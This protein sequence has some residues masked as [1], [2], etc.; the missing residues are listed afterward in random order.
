M[1]GTTFATTTIPF[2]INMSESVNVTGTPRIA[3]DVGGVTR[4]ATYASGTGTS[5]LTFNYDMVAGDVDLD[6]VTLTSPIDLNGGTLK[7]LNGNNATLTFTVPNTSNIKVNYPSLGMDF[8]ADADGRFTLNGTAYNDLSSFVT[9][10]GGNFTRASAATSQQSDGTWVSFASGQPRITNKGLLIEGSIRNKNANY[11]ANPTNTTGLTLGG[12]PSATLSVANDTAALATAGLQNIVTSG[13]VYKLDNSAGTAVASAQIS[14]GTGNTNT[15]VGSVYIRVDSG[16]YNLR[17]SSS[18]SSFGSGSNTAYIRKLWGGS[19]T[20]NPPNG[21][22]LMNIRA[23]AGSVV[24][25]ILN[26]LEE[27]S[28]A[29]SLIVVAGAAATREADNFTIPAGTWYSSTAGTFRTSTYHSLSGTV[30]FD[31]NSSS[32]S[33]SSLWNDSSNWIFEVQSSGSSQASI[34]KT[35]TASDIETNAMSYAN[36]NFRFSKEGGAISSDTSGTVP[37]MTQLYIGRN[38]NNIGY[39]GGYIRNFKYYP[40]SVPDTQLQLLT[41]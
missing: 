34:T 38:R 3:V 9:A 20:F 32:N 18:G 13:M 5:A 12:D 35:W 28:F 10:A 36:N 31:F 11:N 37:S 14:G 4:Y 2:T 1:T 17:L 16:S 6:G 23:N 39:L 41:Q 25:F 22:T 26:Q 7:D 24:Y 15:H 19:G 40:L 33:L 30:V 29:S 8:T 27:S 21:S